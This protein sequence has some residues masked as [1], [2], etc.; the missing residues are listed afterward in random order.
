MRT[1]GNLDRLPTACAAARNLCCHAAEC[2]DRASGEIVPTGSSVPGLIHK[3]PV[4]VVGI[5]VPCDAP[6]MIKA[7]KLS[8]ALAAGNSVV[9]KPAEAVSPAMLR[10]TECCAAAG[11]TEGAPNVVTG[12]GPVVGSAIAHDPRVRVLALSGSG[13]AGGEI[14]CASA[15]SNQRPAY[16][17]LGGKCPN[18]VFAD[19]PDLEA[20]AA[21]TAN[22]FLMNSGQICAAPQRL[23][24]EDSIYEEFSPLAAAQ[25]AVRRAWR[26]K[27][28]RSRR[29]ENRGVFPVFGIGRQRED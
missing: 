11:L 29:A 25:P 13:A 7:G 10:R 28:A 4:G 14:L 18:I 3:V 17:E 21:V 15:A 1:E 26:Q 2:I 23:L 8:A 22:A 12:S 5:I 19:A 6:T 20:A 27:R 9:P 24:T 16:L